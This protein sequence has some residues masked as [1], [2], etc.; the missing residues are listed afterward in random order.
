MSESE[1][2]SIM[3]LMELENDFKLEAVNTSYDLANG[4]IKIGLTNDEKCQMSNV[5][6]HSPEMFATSSMANAYIAKFPD[7]I[8]HTLASLKQGGFMNKKKKKMVN[9]VELHLCIL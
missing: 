3:Q 9:L 1:N 4:Y 5:I 8:N 6:Q 7:G 2:N